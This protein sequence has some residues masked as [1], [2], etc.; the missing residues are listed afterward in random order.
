MWLGLGQGP[1]D[2]GAS[3]S[4]EVDAKGIIGVI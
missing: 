1:I 2:Q 3:G 4:Q